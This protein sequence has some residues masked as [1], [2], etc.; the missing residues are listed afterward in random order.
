MQAEFKL[1]FLCLCYKSKLDTIFSK[2]L[3]TV[4]VH[5]TKQTLKLGRHSDVIPCT[6]C[7]IS[8]A[9]WAGNIRWHM[10]QKEGICFYC[11]RKIFHT[12]SEYILCTISFVQGGFAPS[13]RQ[14]NGRKS[15]YNVLQ[16]F[17][18][19]GGNHC[20]SEI[21]SCRFLTKRCSLADIHKNMSIIFSP[22]PL[23]NKEKFPI[24]FCRLST[25]DNEYKGRLPI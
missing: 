12:S 24:Y 3:V 13:L 11:R 20:D 2:V 18:K 19:N 4:N 22:T 6:D 14:P 25:T 23:S 15:F 9:C 16:A 8:G 7:H 10:I 21:F 5:L 1:R 17:I